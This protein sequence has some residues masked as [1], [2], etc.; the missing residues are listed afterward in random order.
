MPAGEAMSRR[1]LLEAGAAWLAG[2]ALLGVAGCGPRGGDPEGKISAGAER[3]DAMAR[4]VEIRTSRGA[5]RCW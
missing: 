1:G 3:G 2:I 4:E 5:P